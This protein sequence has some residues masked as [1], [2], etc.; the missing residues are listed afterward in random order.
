[1]NNPESLIDCV[2]RA[3]AERNA[4]VDWDKLGV[5]AQDALREDAKA[6]IAA[7]GGVSADDHRNAGLVTGSSPTNHTLNQIRE[8][9]DHAKHQMYNNDWDEVQEGYT[10][11]SAS[12]R[13]VCAALDAINLIIEA[14]KLNNEPREIRLNEESLANDIARVVRLDSGKG[15]CPGVTSN[16]IGKK[17][18]DEIRPYLKREDS[19]ISDNLRS[20]PNYHEDDIEQ[21]AFEL[22][23]ELEEADL[24]ANDYVT[25]NREKLKAIARRIYA[26]LPMREMKDFPK[27]SDKC[28]EDIERIRSAK[29]PAKPNMPI[30]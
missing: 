6:A 12:Y 14:P 30:D 4:Y 11:E 29:A 27:M 7:M 9:L 18:I 1:M 24:K 28:R 5:V 19:E 17:I 10:S 25:I 3:I 21:L 13:K 8:A 16:E 26:K 2:A 23:F 15:F 22:A 20:R